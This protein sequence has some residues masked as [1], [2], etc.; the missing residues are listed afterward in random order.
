MP[1]PLFDRWEN[2]SPGVQLTEVLS[3]YSSLPQR[4]NI[5]SNIFILSPLGSTKTFIHCL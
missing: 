4:K 2:K 3:K 1:I 5:Y